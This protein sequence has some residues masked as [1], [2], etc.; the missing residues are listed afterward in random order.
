MVK[1]IE[2]FEARK[3]PCKECGKLKVRKRLGARKAPDY[4]PECLVK[5][6]KRQLKKAREE[7][8]KNKEPEGIMVIAPDGFSTKVKNEEEKRFYESR[9]SKY[10]GEFDWIDSADL[11]LLSRLLSLEIS[12]KRYESRFKLADSEAR[13]KLNSIREIRE[14]QEQ[15]GITRLQRKKKKEE[16]TPLDMVQ[17]L[18]KRFVNQRKKNPERF[19]WI[20]KFCGK[21]NC[22][23]MRNPNYKK[24][25]GATPI[26][27]NLK[28]NDIDE[29]T[30]TWQ[31][32]EGLNA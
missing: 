22:L 18:V 3:Y 15:L 32:R 21:K 14:L 6:R 31:Q 25:T 13:D 1:S 11:S 30:L 16:R 20:C 12:C 29:K 5:I 23:M 9:K 19:V 7:K 10:L 27:D 4:C 28:P 26:E 24:E 2:D 17:G 8:D